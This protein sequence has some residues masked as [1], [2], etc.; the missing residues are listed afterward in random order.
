MAELTPLNQSALSQLEIGRSRSSTYLGELAEVLGVNLDW[1]VLG[2]GDML[3]TTTSEY[4]EAKQLL[5]EMDPA[6]LPTVLT[7]LRSLS[8]Q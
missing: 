4:S 5:D 7:L 2:K 6:H 1:L 8:G 3:R